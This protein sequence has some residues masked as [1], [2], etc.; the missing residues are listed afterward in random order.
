MKHGTTGIILMGTITAKQ[1]LAVQVINHI[2]SPT[3]LS[4]DIAT[5]VLDRYGFKGCRSDVISQS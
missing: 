1:E 3:A 5:H 2:K 4:P